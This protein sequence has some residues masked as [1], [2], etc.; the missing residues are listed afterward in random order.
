MTDFRNSGSRV[1]T[2]RTRRVPG[3]SRCSLRSGPQYRTLREEFFTNIWFHQRSLFLSRRLCAM[4]RSSENY[5]I[6]ASTC[7]VAE[8]S[9]RD[10]GAE[11][12]R[13]SVPP[14]L[15]RRWIK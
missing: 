7:A 2:I 9:R 11:A 1:S 10:S 14:S 12:L 5:Q 13:E 15:L 3:A 4:P 6:Y 8:L